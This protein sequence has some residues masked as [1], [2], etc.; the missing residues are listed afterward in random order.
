MSEPQCPHLEKGL[1]VKEI[2]CVEDLPPCLHVVSMRELV[3]AAA[4]IR[5]AAWVP[6]WAVVQVALPRCRLTYLLAPGLGAL[7]VGRPG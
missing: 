3:A 6:D 2:I 4:G 5:L 7:G 1:I